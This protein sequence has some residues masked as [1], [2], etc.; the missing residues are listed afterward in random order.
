M[1]DL[2]EFWATGIERTRRDLAECEGLVGFYTRRAETL[3]RE[4]A[5]ADKM[6][7]ALQA[8]TGTGGE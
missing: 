7:R 5:E 3:R 1:S 4:L 2:Q 6:W 8:N